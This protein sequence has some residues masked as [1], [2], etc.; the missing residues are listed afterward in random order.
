[1]NAGAE[2]TAYTSAVCMYYLVENKR[3]LEKLRAEIEAVVPT[4][5]TGWGLPSVAVLRKLQYLE[6]CFKEFQR[7]RSIIN[8]PSERVVP[9]AGATIA[10]V[11][12]FGGTIVSMDTGGLFANPAIYGPDVDGYRPERWI[13]ASD[14]QRT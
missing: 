2:T 8:I 6:A 1:M 5:T 10:G 13:E 9:K 14:E 3:V 4:T 7:L 11:D 12:I